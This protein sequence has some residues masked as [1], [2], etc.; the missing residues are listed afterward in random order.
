[1]FCSAPF[2]YTTLF[3]SHEAVFHVGFDDRSAMRW[4][5]DPAKC[6]AVHELRRQL[7]EHALRPRFS[8]GHVAAPF[9]LRWASAA[10]MPPAAARRSEEH[11]SELQSRVDL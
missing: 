2:P 4:W 11:T 9:S 10:V 6:R 1:V 5:A 3:R 7:R 8:L